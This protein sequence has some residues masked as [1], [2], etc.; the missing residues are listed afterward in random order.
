[1]KSLDNSHPMF[2]LLYEAPTCQMLDLILPHQLETPTGGN[3]IYTFDNLISQLC[4]THKT[5]SFNLFNKI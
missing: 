1:M 2:Y 4:N 3:L 5:V